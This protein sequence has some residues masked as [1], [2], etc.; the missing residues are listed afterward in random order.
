MLSL[1]VFPLS[2]YLVYFTI[3]IENVPTSLNRLRQLEDALAAA[4]VEVVALSLLAQEREEDRRFT[5]VR[6]ILQTAQL[7]AAAAIELRRAE[8]NEIETI[9]RRYGE[10]MR[11]WG[12]E[13]SA[14]EPWRARTSGTLKSVD[15]MS[16][17]LS[18]EEQL[19]VAV[20]DAAGGAHSSD[21]VVV[22]EEESARAL[23]FKRMRLLDNG[24]GMRAMLLGKHSFSILHLA[25]H[26]ILLLL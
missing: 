6:D 7:A 3:R 15:V 5:H 14:T 20:D 17:D 12:G 2:L 10:L 8:M 11:A 1:T 24:S 16:N 23:R 13:S 4:D 26:L 9:R 21:A 22:K 19:R 25:L 18:S